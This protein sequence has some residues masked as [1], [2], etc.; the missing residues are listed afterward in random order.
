MFTG[1]IRLKGQLLAS[2]VG[3]AGGRLVIDAPGLQP[4]IGDSVAVAGVC[5]TVTASQGTGHHFDLAL[6]TLARTTL[7]RLKP[8]DLVNLEPSLHLGDALDGHLVMGHVDATAEVVAVAGEG[9]GAR[10]TVRLPEDIAALTAVKGS[11]S[12]D[13]VSLTVAA[14]GPD[15]TASFA[16][17]PYTL[18]ETTLGLLKPGMSVNIEA[19]VI[20]RY[21]ARSLSS[22]GGGPQ[23]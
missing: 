17:L 1:I 13:G 20:A 21:V 5:L 4:Q 12:V 14:L 18:T 8:G 2:E 10:L 9:D 22:V 7:G 11:L 15:E 6:E 23:G 3:T 16:L 19:D